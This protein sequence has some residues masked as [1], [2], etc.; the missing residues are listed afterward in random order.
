MRAEIITL[1]FMSRFDTMISAYRDEVRKCK[2]AGKVR[3]VANV[4]WEE[5]ASDEDESEVVAHA[6]LAAQLS[7]Q[8]AELQALREEMGAQSKAREAAAQEARE[9][10]L[11]AQR[12]RE[13]MMEGAVKF[14]L[15]S[16]GAQS[17]TEA[18]EAVRDVFTSP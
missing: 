16:G 17:R 9:K 4:A 18:E 1:N 7:E 12:D 15:E 14:A 5:D 3:R 2:E 11:A 13:I 10:E 8:Q 6:A